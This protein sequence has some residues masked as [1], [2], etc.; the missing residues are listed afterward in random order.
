MPHS[1]PQT[2]AEGGA[3]EQGH[4]QDQDHPERQLASPQ[5]GQPQ[6]TASPMQQSSAA[7]FWDA[8]AEDQPEALNSPS[9]A[10]GGSHDYGVDEQTRLIPGEESPEDLEQTRITA[11]PAPAVKKLCL[12]V[13]DG[14]E[15]LVEKAAV[16]GRNPAAADGAEQLVLK[17]G[18]RSV[19]K[20]HLRIDDSGEDITVTDLGSTN[21]STIVHEDGSR[22][23]LHP[24][25]A[26]IL[27]LGAQL[28]LGDRALSVEREQ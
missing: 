24:D 19:S 10:A 6:H 18:T 23:T 22:E 13:D 16:I 14:T 11:V 1:Q 8:P 4:D 28:T 17:D 25:A 3:L 26:T 27:P 2:Q 15:L 9:G 7:P 21:G 5:W 20:T 12:T